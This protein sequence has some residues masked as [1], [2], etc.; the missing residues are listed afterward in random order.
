MVIK[1]R[2]TLPDY[3]SSHDSSLLSTDI[4][5]TNYTSSTSIVDILS[6]TENNEAT[7]K[8]ELYTRYS[9]EKMVFWL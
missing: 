1:E 8:K 2:W 4:K 6:L 9:T 3:E 5:S 7:M